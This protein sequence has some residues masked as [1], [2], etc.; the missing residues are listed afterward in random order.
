VLGS[1]ALLL[2]LLCGYRRDSASAVLNM[3]ARCRRLRR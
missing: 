2:L 1:N 3:E